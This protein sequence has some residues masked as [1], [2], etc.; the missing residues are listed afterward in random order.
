MLPGTE[1]YALLTLYAP[2]H[3][4]K[5]A[6][7]HKKCCFLLKADFYD[8]LAGASALS[9]EGLNSGF[10]RRHRTNLCPQ[11]PL[12]KPLYDFF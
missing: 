5:K 1:T 2:P 3:N 12:S 7:H 6:D 8:R 4:A 9:F 11:T 10:K